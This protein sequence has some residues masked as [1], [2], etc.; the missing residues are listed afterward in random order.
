MSTFGEQ[1][2]CFSST[3]TDQPKKSTEEKMSHNHWL[4]FGYLIEVLKNKIY[5]QND[6]KVK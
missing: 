5:S 2:M 4:Q 1:L 3:E 6:S